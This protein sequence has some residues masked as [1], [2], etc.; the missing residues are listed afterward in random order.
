MTT[1][2]NGLN[3]YTA[4]TVAATPSS[5]A[6]GVAATTTTA[7]ASPTISLSNSATVSLSGAVV[8]ATNTPVKF[9]A[10]IAAFKAAKTPEAVAALP[11][12]TI[13]DASTLLTSSPDARETL[14]AMAVAGKI[15]S[16]AFTDT[17]A[18]KFT[19]DRAAIS[20]PLDGKDN[21]SPAV[22]VL[23]K[24]TTKYSLAITGI[25]ASDAGTVKPP[26]ANA[27]LSFSVSD[28][29]GGVSANLVT[30]QTLA[31]AKALIAVNVANDTSKQIIYSAN[32]N[33]NYNDGSVI[34]NGNAQINAN[35]GKDGSDAMYFD[36]TNSFIVLNNDKLNFG[37]Q[38]FD[39]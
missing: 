19:F 28:N 8:V 29:V 30:L 6:T 13:K 38:D 35:Q 21:P 12:Y 27:A 11:I 9:A 7:K 15:N 1:I 14:M 39:F 24:I 2:T 10:A 18:P 23:Q 20:G 32:F 37:V 31:K 25:S 5:G 3:A 36:G 4:N 34:L 33:P 26:V 16:I 22:M 17:T